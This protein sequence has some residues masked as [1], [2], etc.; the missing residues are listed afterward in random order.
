[1]KK[2]VTNPIHWRI[3]TLLSL[4]T[5]QL[6]ELSIRANGTLTSYRVLLGRCLVALQESNG[7]KDYGCSSATHYAVQL[8]GMKKKP[9]QEYQRVARDLIPLHKLTRVAELGQI[10][11]TKLREITRVA[12]PRTEEYWMKLAE[13]L[14]CSQLEKLVGKTPKGSV[15]GEWSEEEESVV[16]E[17]RCP[18]DPRLFRMLSEALRILIEERGESVTYADL[19][20]RALVAF[21]TGREVDE[22]VLER[23][24]REA[25]RDLL[26]LQMQRKPLFR[27]A[28][29]LAREM[30]LLED[31]GEPAP[32]EQAEE[33]SE[34]ADTLEELAYAL[35]GL[36]EEVSKE[37]SRGDSAQSPSGESTTVPIRI[38]DSTSAPSRGVN[39]VGRRSSNKGGSRAAGGNIIKVGSDISTEIEN[40]LSTNTELDIEDFSV[41]VTSDQLVDGRPVRVDL[42]GTG[43]AAAGMDPTKP[44]RGDVGEA[45]CNCSGH[46]PARDGECGTGCNC[47]GHE[48]ARGGECKPGCN[49][50]EPGRDGRCQEHK[51]ITWS[52]TNHRGKPGRH[53]LPDNPW[54]RRVCFNPSSRHLTGAQRRECLRRDG[55]KCSVPGCHHRAWLHIHHIVQFSHGGKTVPEN[56][57][58]VCSACHRN[59]HDGFLI[60]EIDRNGD[61]LFSDR[62]GRRLDRVI[63]LEVAGWIDFWLGWTGGE[64]DSHRA[65]VMRNEWDVLF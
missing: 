39:E 61:P 11:W 16:T 2:K 14:N 8:L 35:G 41:L 42:A 12:V 45:G 65:R 6:H 29:E 1:M 53:P 3:P 57:I 18:V 5:E 55:F 37:L 38:E 31:G 49:G 20:E 4:G 60:L 63:S 52:K 58:T 51:R 27:E 19:L 13:Q 23:A 56:L 34:E 28:R 21:I 24:R 47:K 33:S 9:A 44:V 46:K 50:C 40:L 26:A 54:T 15:P 25:D 62:H 59:L 10:D 32:E 17:L 7:Y 43:D 36:M 48:P 30:G 22:K 64:E